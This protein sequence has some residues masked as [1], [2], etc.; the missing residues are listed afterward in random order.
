LR[1][2]ALPQTAFPRADIGDECGSIS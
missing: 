2:R 1:K